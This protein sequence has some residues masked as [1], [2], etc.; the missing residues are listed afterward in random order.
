MSIQNI[1]DNSK[2]DGFFCKKCN[3][4]P[5]IEIIPKDNK[6]LSACKCHK[7]YENIETFIQN[8]SLKEKIDINIISNEPLNNFFTE[9]NM[10]INTIKQKFEKAK[11][12]LI[13]SS[14]ELKNKLTLFI[15][16]I[17]INFEENIFA[18]N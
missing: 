2:Y 4:I 17:L 15:L 9:T 14:I 8:K 1:N 18:M 10:D 13:H 12:D 7:Q 16:C 3:S 5:L 11:D 6:I